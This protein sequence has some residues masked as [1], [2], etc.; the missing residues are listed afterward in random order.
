MLIKYTVP[1]LAALSLVGCGGYKMVNDESGDGS[2]F[3]VLGSASSSEKLLDLE[4]TRYSDKLSKNYYDYPI[5]YYATFR[6]DV[7]QSGEAPKV[8]GGG[9]WAAARD[10]G[11]T[12]AAADLFGSAIFGGSGMGTGFNIS[13]I[14]LSLIAPRSPEERFVSASRYA[15]KTFTQ[16]GVTFIRVDSVSERASFDEL[17]RLFSRRNAE[18]RSQIK[19]AGFQCDGKYD[20]VISGLYRETPGTFVKCSFRDVTF[21]VKRR[22]DLAMPESIS[23]KLYGPGVVSF[24]TYSSLQESLVPVILASHAKLIDDGW[25][26]IYPEYSKGL[27]R[28]IVVSQGGVIKRYPSPK[29]MFPEK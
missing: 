10:I 19:S 7:L 17:N 20:F 22:S 29:N 4:M 13:M 14:G 15:Y 26:A 9:A 27:M 2:Q 6:N 25:T 23:R 21:H 16:P 1:A 18:L 8:S 5:Q 12:V 24:L 11:G 28:E 3:T